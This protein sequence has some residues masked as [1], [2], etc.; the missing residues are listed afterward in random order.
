MFDGP[1]PKDR[2]AYDK[3]RAEMEPRYA[4][5][6]K[7]KALRISKILT[8]GKV[9]RKTFNKRLEI[10]EECEFFTRWRRCTKCGCF[11][12]NKGRY[13]AA[14]CPEGKWN[15]IKGEENG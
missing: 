5:I 6:L 15:A 3:R 13:K 8:S 7:K 14:S 4:E 10:C 2:E 12:G 11:M 9:D 1:A